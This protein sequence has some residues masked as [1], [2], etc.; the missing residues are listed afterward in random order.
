MP[1]GD[2]ASLFLEKWSLMARKSV[3]SCMSYSL[4]P[5]GESVSPVRTVGIP[6][7]IVSNYGRWTVADQHSTSKER[8]SLN[9]FLDTDNEPTHDNPDIW[10]TEKPIQA[11]Y[12]PT[13]SAHLDGCVPGSIWISKA[14]DINLM[15]SRGGVAS[16]IEENRQADEVLQGVCLRFRA[17]WIH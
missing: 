4:V 10:F 5:S 1:S 17:Y 14:N 13:S 16:S 15:S 9:A 3:E 8:L 2:I 11:T 7:P 6:S 12:Y